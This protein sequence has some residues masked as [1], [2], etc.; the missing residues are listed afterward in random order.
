MCQEGILYK[1]NKHKVTKKVSRMG[2]L[3]RF[4]MTAEEVGHKAKP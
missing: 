4:R 2:L 3:A 1:A